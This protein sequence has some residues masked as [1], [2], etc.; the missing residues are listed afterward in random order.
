MI[1]AGAFDPGTQGHAEAARLLLDIA[2]A[3]CAVSAP[4][5]LG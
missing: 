1:R 4:R 5:A 3:R 2:R